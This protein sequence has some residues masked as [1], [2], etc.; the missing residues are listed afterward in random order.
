M[1]ETFAFSLPY[2]ERVPRV[3]K[4]FAFDPS[5]IAAED[6]A[7]TDKASINKKGLEIE[8]ILQKGEILSYL[9][10]V[11]GS[12]NFPTE[13]DPAISG[14]RFNLFGPWWN[15]IRLHNMDD[16]ACKLVEKAPVNGQLNHYKIEEDKNILPQSTP[17]V[18]NKKNDQ[19]H[20]A[21]AT[22]SAY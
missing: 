8:R 11:V 7:P 19:S 18:S 3:S 9:R 21:V 10:A 6:D 17:S 13:K 2:D 20:S 12:F 1:A 22:N 15:P 16:L 5:P 14:V 4:V